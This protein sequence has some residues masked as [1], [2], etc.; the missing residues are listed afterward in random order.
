[1]KF[2]KNIGGRSEKTSD[3]LLN[4]PVSDKDI[5]LLAVMCEKSILC[6]KRGFLPRRAYTYY[7]LIDEANID[8]ARDLFMRNGFSVECHKYDKDVYPH[9]LLRIEHK[10]EAVANRI[11]NLMETV[12]K[13]K[14]KLLLEYYTK[15]KDARWW[16]IQGIIND[17]KD[18]APER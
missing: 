1:M 5:D 17:I 12:S 2:L 18:V 4:K 14:D 11:K 10:S 13:R 16:G 7:F 15:G 8:V 9:T 3:S 6:V